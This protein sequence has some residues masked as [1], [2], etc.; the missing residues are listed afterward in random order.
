MKRLMLLTV[1]GCM[2]ALF[3]SNAAQAATT[4]PPPR[5]L[6]RHS[7]AELQRRLVFLPALSDPLSG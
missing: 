1:L 6:I 7:R 4:H 3:V 5:I 2:F